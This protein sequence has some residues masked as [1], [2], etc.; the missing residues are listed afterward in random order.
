M[1]WFSFIPALCPDLSASRTVRKILDTYNIDLSWNRMRKALHVFENMVMV[2]MP[3]QS[4][5]QTR[6][7]FKKRLLGLKAIYKVGGDFFCQIIYLFLFYTS[8]WWSGM[9]F[10]GLWVLYSSRLSRLWTPSIPG[11]IPPFGSWSPPIQGWMNSRPMKR[12]D[13][14]AQ[15]D[16]WCVRL[17][18]WSKAA[19][20]SPVTLNM[21]SGVRI[22]HL[23]KSFNHGHALLHSRPFL[24]KHIHN[25]CFFQRVRLKAWGLSGQWWVTKSD[26]KVISS[27]CAFCCRGMLPSI[28]DLCLKPSN[29][30]LTGWFLYSTFYGEM[31]MSPAISMLHKY[32]THQWKCADWGWICAFL[33][34][35]QHYLWWESILYITYI[36]ILSS[37]LDNIFSSLFFP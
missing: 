8:R 36:Y 37:R 33:P 16:W 20:S 28:D 24:L 6:S 23:T 25:H 18:E 14:S 15:C 1:N 34:R 10:F 5:R 27:H 19:G 21:S 12:L 11:W 4:R 7:S 26:I 22:P 9:A 35:V 3:E 29:F 13:R 30:F 17:A 32:L 2:L 31:G